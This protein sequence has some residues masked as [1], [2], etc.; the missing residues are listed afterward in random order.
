MERMTEHDI[1]RLVDALDAGRQAWIGGELDA[2]ATVIARRPTL[3]REA[4]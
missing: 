4:S 3:L 1:Q 2:R